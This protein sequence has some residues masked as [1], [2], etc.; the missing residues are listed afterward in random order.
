M[1]AVWAHRG[2]A[3]RGR[4][5]TIEALL[6]ARELGAD[7]VELDVRRSADGA[8]VVHH[9]P[10]VPGVGAVAAHAAGDLPAH[11]PLLDAALDACR[12][13]TVNVEV[14]NAPH[15]PG[16]DPD[17]R[18]AAET[19]KVVEAAGLRE[20]VI[21]SSFSPDV[22][23][24]VLRTDPDLAVGWLLGVG[25]RPGDVV[26]EAVARGYR[27]IHPFVT[28]VEE[29]TVRRAHG[30]GVAIHVWTVNTDT[31]LRRMARLGVDAVI[32][33]DVVAALEALRS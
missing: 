12:G 24:A 6:E 17:Q 18:I 31:D 1:T 7:G 25:Q 28:D 19:A 15:E 20:S 29:T 32:T 16:F 4:E 3:S 14:K 22:L 21:V 27:A 2:A 10:V 11:I 8:L 13:M 30:R 9:D 23:D 26:D 33:D 5:N